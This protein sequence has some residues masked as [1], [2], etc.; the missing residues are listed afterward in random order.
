MD[1]NIVGFIRSLTAASGLRIALTIALTTG[2]VLVAYQGLAS[3][4]LLVGCNL[5]TVAGALYMEYRNYQ[6]RL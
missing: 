6:A 1:N 5:I 2:S 4:T 3:P